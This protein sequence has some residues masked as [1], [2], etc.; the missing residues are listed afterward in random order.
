MRFGEPMNMQAG[1]GD[2]LGEAQGIEKIE[3][4]DNTDNLVEGFEISADKEEMIREYEKMFE[5]MEVDEFENFKKV[6]ES[7]PQEV[8]EALENGDTG[9]LVEHVKKKG[10]FEKRV[11]QFVVFALVTAF[12]TGAFAAGSDKVKKV[13]MG[14]GSDRAKFERVE[15]M[16]GEG[17]TPLDKSGLKLFMDKNS[18]S[19]DIDS[20]LE[21]YYDK[22]RGNNSVVDSKGN[23]EATGKTIVDGESI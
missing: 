6:L 4:I 8:I 21:A 3:G 7:A 5:E 18:A 12:S 13:S 15:E 16:R 11:V 1:L 20:D 14:H 17:S 19:K 9:Q 22:I 23:M 2:N 10:I